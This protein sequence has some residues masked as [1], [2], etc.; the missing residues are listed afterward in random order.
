MCFNLPLKSIIGKCEKKTFPYVWIMKYH[1]LGTYY[2]RNFIYLNVIN[3]HNND[4]SPF[5]YFIDQETK[6]QVK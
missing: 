3:D 1:S 4:V 6:E 2:D 5:L